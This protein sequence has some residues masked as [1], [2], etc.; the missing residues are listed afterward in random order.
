VQEIAVLL[1]KAFTLQ[2]FLLHYF[3]QVPEILKSIVVEIVYIYICKIAFFLKS[4]LP[5]LSRKGKSSLY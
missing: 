3:A 5:S 1:S 2:H 4:D